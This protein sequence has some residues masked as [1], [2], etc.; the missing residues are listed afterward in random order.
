MKTSRLGSYFPMHHGTTEWLTALAVHQNDDDTLNLK[1][2]GQDVQRSV[3]L[4][5]YND[6]LPNKAT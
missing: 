1:V 4:T 2:W 6:E 3:K 5:W